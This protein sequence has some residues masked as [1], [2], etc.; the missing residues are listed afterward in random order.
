MTSESV[1]MVRM[2]GEVERRTLRRTEAPGGL[3]RRAIWIGMSL[4]CFVA[5]FTPYN[6]YVLHNSPFIGNHFPIGIVTLVAAL[7]LLVNPL[8]SVFTKKPLTTAELI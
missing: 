8:L 6:D 4:V 5:A 7:I 2:G 3:T 1:D